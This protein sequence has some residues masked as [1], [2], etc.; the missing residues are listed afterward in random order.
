[1]TDTQSRRFDDAPFIRACR[2]QPVDRVPV[3]F[4]RQAGRA[5]PEYR[6]ARGPGSILDAIAQPEL[7]ARLTRQPVDRYGTDAAIFFSDIVVPAAAIGFGVDVAPGTGP[8]VLEP[9]AGRRD[10]QRLRPLEPEIDT[11]YVIE[12]VGLLAD[13]LDVPLI[14]FAGG[15]FTVASYLVEGGPSKNF[16]K[17]K[18]L[19]HGDPGLWHD[20]MERLGDLALASLRSQVDA[21]ASAVQIFD[22]WAGILTP[23]HYRELVL[24]TTQ[25]LFAELART[26]PGIPTILFGVGTGELL[27]S[28]AT[29]GSTVVGVDWRVPLDE[30]RRRVGADL[31]VQG[32]LDPALCLG[33]WE[34]AA[35]E[36][37]VVLEAAGEQPGHV[38]N[39]GHG[40][41]PET[42][43][44]ILEQVV[45]LVHAEGR[46]GVGAPS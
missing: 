24:P 26:H 11:P 21:G 5:L 27:P 12:A 20:L 6:A 37:R 23:A 14:G 4:M 39:L 33:T 35:A 19:M 17:V 42:D 9:F 25:R 34:V 1:V 44:G 7:V 22:S 36:T 30:A 29:A 28:M 41:L 31:A 32:N 40:V 10:L 18:A 16:T 45:E 2:R 46:A 3:W 13:E 15:P 8:V 38:F 43:P